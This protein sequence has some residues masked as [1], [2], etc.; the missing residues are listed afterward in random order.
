VLEW[1][2]VEDGAA[3]ED[4]LTVEEVTVEEATAAGVFKVLV[5]VA[6]VDPEE[7]EADLAL[8]AAVL[9]E[10]RAVDVLATDIVVEVAAAPLSEK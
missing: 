10:D 6:T 3:A 9:A 5:L 4:K 1:I 7:L 2:D 8:D